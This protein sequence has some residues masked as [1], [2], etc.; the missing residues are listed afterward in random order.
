MSLLFALALIFTL[1]AQQSSYRFAPGAGG[2][3]ILVL[4]PA[5][6][7]TLEAEFQTWTQIAATRKWNLFAPTAGLS[8]DAGLKQ[9]ESWLSEL[10]TTHK[11]EQAPCYLVGAGAAAAG[12]FYAAA[13]IPHLWTAA[14]AISGSPKPAI[15]SDR[16]FAANT[17]N[18][19]VAW[20][21]T[22]EERQ[23]SDALRAKML[24]AGYNLTVLESA[25]IEQVL[26]FLARHRFVAYP[27]A[28]DC[29]T[30]NPQLARCYWITVT[31]FD[32]AL[33]NDALRSSRIP[34][35]HLGASLDLGGFGFK[36]TTPGPGVLVEYLPENYRGP[37][38]LNDR[39][40]ALSDKQIL[41]AKHYVELMSQVTEER[42]VSVTI[43]RTEK[44][45]KERI[46]LTTS[47]KLRKREEVIT[48]RIQASYA[49]EAKEITIISRAVAEIQIQVPDAWTP[50]IITWNGN[51]MASPQQG[52]CLAL[53]LKSPGSSRPCGP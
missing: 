45:E 18:V 39:I 37:L 32:P 30:G 33:R 25:T 31:A 4:L 2:A 14:V 49:S 13:R 24:A 47:Y 27:E 8:G 41:D 21:V 48:A 35:D 15:D 46:R 12:V 10:R 5:A 6:A 40:V 50:A 53:S 29:E 20:A 19:P 3:P 9:L 16:I 51:Q 43:E 23:S 26:D 1:P 28:I 44:K 36:L 34:P 7:E 52:G 22:P 42:P 11:L 38:K 17:G